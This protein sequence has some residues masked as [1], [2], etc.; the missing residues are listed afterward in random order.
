MDIGDVVKGLKEGKRYRR[1]GWNGRNIFIELLVPDKGN[2]M[3]PSFHI[4]RYNRVRD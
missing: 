2:M 3:T 4:H 1:R